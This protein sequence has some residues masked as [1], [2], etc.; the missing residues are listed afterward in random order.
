MAQLRHLYKLFI[1]KLDRPTTELTY[2]T[3]PYLSNANEIEFA[4]LA[5]SSEV[6]YC[7]SMSGKGPFN[8]C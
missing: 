1:S 6:Q 8:P 7:Q 4:F 3:S 2:A 5:Y